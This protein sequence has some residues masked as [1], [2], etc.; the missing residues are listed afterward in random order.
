MYFWICYELRVAWLKKYSFL[1]EEGTRTSKV[2]RPVIFQRLS[3]SFF[4]RRSLWTFPR[5]FRDAVEILSLIRKTIKQLSGICSLSS[6]EITS[7]LRAMIRANQIILFMKTASTVKK[8][9]L[10]P[11]RCL[12]F[13][14]SFSHENCSDEFRSF[15]GALFWKIIIP[16]S[17]TEMFY[18][19]STK[20]FLLFN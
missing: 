8:Q 1:S 2:L 12:C 15:Y 4:S 10:F 19:W 14:A 16:S 6:A 7:A 3:P 20:A 5:A 11:V 9:F 13:F 18:M 17:L